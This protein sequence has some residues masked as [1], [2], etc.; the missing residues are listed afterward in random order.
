LF[1]GILTS[2]LIESRQDLEEDP[3]ERLLKEILRTLRNASDT[4]ASPP[5]QPD[6]AV[7]TIN[8]LWFTS[9]TLTLC[10]ALG[11]V[12]AKGWISKY[13]SSSLRK[14]SKD[15]CS[16]LLR[17]TRIRQWGVGGI[18]TSISLLIQIAL[19]LF[20]IGLG[21]LLWE[22]PDRI[23]TVILILVSVTGL[24]YVIATF[25]PM[26]F[27]ACPLQTPL[28]V[29]QKEI[30]SKN[31]NRNLE[32]NM[33]SG[34]RR[35]QKLLESWVKHIKEL[36]QSPS[37]AELQ[38]R[39]IAWTIANTF[40]KDAF[41]EAIKALAGVQGASALRSAF[42]D[43]GAT[44]ALNQKLSLYFKPSSESS[45]ADEEEWN[46][47]VLYALLN[48]A[49]LGLREEIQLL[50]S[51]KGTLSQWKQLRRDDH[52]AL[53]LCIRIYHLINCYQD[54]PDVHNIP[55]IAAGIVPGIAGKYTNIERI[56]ALAALRGITDGREDV[57]EACIQVLGD[58]LEHCKFL[59][60]I[61]DRYSNAI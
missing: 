28:T 7:I 1:A 55:D 39:V 15:A 32:E 36:V 5:F 61:G 45:F 19:L 54:D 42:R 10:S 26:V 52:R 22:T 47:V 25:L 56:L 21:Y 43:F 24:L 14:T 46:E 23:R 9:L 57:K 29:W 50:F 40:R 11:G 3:Q 30:T 44:A 27:P 8:S 59:K 33:R 17:S 34:G 49:Q 60:L 37:E 58:L 53:A 41:K 2:F 4:A 38:A 13:S 18:I 48:V 20:F 31:R 35:L 51:S 6:P 16:R 12:L